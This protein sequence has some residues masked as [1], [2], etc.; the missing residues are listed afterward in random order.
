MENKEERQISK[1]DGTTSRR[2]KLLIWVAAVI[3]RKRGKFRDEKVC[4]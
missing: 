2:K 4:K 3:P 1:V